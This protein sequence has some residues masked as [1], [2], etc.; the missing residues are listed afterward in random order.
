QEN[1]ESVPRNHGRPTVNAA[2]FK[3]F[4]HQLEI[5][6]VYPLS[7]DEPDSDSAF[8]GVMD[9]VMWALRT[10]PVPQVITDPLTGFQSQLANTGEEMTWEIAA[11]Q[12]LE[13]QRWSWYA[14][15]ITVS[16]LEM[17]QA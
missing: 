7:D 1:R 17:I 12:A 6:V 2:G 13:P 11:P 8:P 5:Y 16:L 10:T 3:N 15:L 4:R 9:E 14:A